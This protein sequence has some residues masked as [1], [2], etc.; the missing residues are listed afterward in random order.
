[1]TPLRWSCSTRSFPLARVELAL[2]IAA[3]LGFKAVDLCVSADSR[4]LPLQLV[5]ADPA[6]S[7]DVVMRLVVA[8][9]MQVVD[10]RAD[11]AAV[12]APELAQFIAFAQRC[13]AAVVTLAWGANNGPEIV[14]G[15]ARLASTAGLQPAIEASAGT[16]PEVIAEM[17]SETGVGIALDYGTFLSSGTVEEDVNTLLPL[18]THMRLRGVASGAFQVAWS[19]NTIDYA[20]AIGALR[21]RGYRGYFAADYVWEPILGRNHNDT[22]A[23]TAQMRRQLDQ[24]C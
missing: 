11:A 7:A 17:A 19:E 12:R 14:A 16:P 10:V 1:M 8:R 18:A 20:R 24:A 13:N 6:G 23:E 4:H 5:L 21:A 9:S 2:R 3:G 22:I 15:F